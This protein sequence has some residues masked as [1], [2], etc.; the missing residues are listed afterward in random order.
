MSRKEGKKGKGRSRFVTWLSRENREALL[1]EVSMTLAFLALAV[2]IVV[3]TSLM[4]R[5]QRLQMENTVERSFNNIALAIQQN[6][7]R[8]SDILDDNMVGVGIYDSSGSLVM[9]WGSIYNM[10]PV[11]TISEEAHQ[12]GND[13]VVNFD[14]STSTVEYIRFLRQP[15]PI[16]SINFFTQTL[17]AGYQMQDPS[18]IIYLSFDGSG[19]VS[20]LRLI[21]LVS[22][23]A[24]VAVIVLYIFVMRLNR[25]NRDYKAQMDKQS[26][27]VNLGQAARTLTHEIKNPL[28]AITIQLALLKRQLRD[29][30]YLDELLL[31][32]SETQRLISLTNR[33]SDFLKNPEGQPEQIDIA[34]LINQL[35]PLFS[36]PITV[37]PT[38]EKQAYILF[39]PD[40][41]RSVVENILKNAVESCEGRDPQVEVEIILG[42]RGVYHVYIRDRGDGIQG[43]VEKLFDPFYTTKIHGSGIGL[44]I[45]RQFLRARGGDIRIMNRPGGGPVVELLVAKYSFVQE[46]VVSTTNRKLEGRK[47]IRGRK[48][49]PEAEDRS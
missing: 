17:G 12:S 11:A 20:V 48:K 27:L 41:L 1:V 3:L 8:E 10:I 44:A 24:F 39:D 35:I 37:L 29:S 28:S 14:S 31:I 47:M 6:R 32:E 45:S 30:E 15:L 42:R 25:E 4:V 38:S 16:T 33:V 7:T 43:D 13:T 9:G 2:L 5:T 49:P 19:Y 26:N 34:A 18:T 40:R 21:F 22:I 36:Y 46:L 23:L